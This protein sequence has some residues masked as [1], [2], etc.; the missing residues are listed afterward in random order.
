MIMRG[1]SEKDSEISRLKIEV[2]NRRG[3]LEKAKE[4]AEI[5][6]KAKVI[7]VQ[8]EL[9]IK[10]EEQTQSW[11]SRVRDLI[12]LRSL[13]FAQY[14]DLK[15]GL[16]EQSFV[17]CIKKIKAAMEEF[18]GREAVI[19]RLIKTDNNES[20]DDALTHFIISSDSGLR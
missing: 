2:D 14:A 3:Q 10:L 19:K 17:Q 9:S 20:I 5:E 1:M 6:F 12:G 8:S 13:N 16:S 4:M 7:S 18:K 11:E 15:S